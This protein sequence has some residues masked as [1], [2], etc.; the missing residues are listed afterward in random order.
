MKWNEGENDV[1]VK[2]KL[3]KDCWR[4]VECYFG[5]YL[6]R[7]FLGKLLVEWNFAQ[8]F[9]FLASLL[10]YCK[11]LQPSL[12]Q[13]RKPTTWPFR[14]IWLSEYSTNLK[15]RNS[16]FWQ[17]SFHVSSEAYFKCC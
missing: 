14:G 4:I 1:G 11:F 2:R 8:L 9:G 6:A 5:F 13:S 3:A 10:S 17:I 15:F 16:I 7:W 12:L